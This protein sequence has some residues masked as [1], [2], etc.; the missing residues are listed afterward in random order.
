MQLVLKHPTS[1]RPV[2]SCHDVAEALG[3]EA[4]DPTL[5]AA[6]QCIG[7]VLAKAY[8]DGHDGKPPGKLT[9]PRDKSGY[10][11][12]YYNY[13]GEAFSKALEMGKAALGDSAA[14]AAKAAAKQPRKAEPAPEPPA[15]A[16]EVPPAKPDESEFDF[17]D[18]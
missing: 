7:R 6:L 9:D 13:T 18:V 3:F 4:D 2:F 17:S 15:D 1:G 12:Y 5:P 10:Q 8:R 14:K 11:I 16:P